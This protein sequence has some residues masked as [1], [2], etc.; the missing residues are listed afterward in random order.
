V[1]NYSQVWTPFYI[2]DS[3]HALIKAK[4]ESKLTRAHSILSLSHTNTTRA[5]R[6][7]TNPSTRPNDV[8]AIEAFKNLELEKEDWYWNLG[9][10]VF[11]MAILVAGDILYDFPSAP[12]TLYGWGTGNLTQYWLVI[13]VQYVIWFGLIAFIL[14]MYTAICITFDWRVWHLWCQYVFGRHRR[15]QHIVLKILGYAMVVFLLAGTM[16]FD[17]LLFYAADAFSAAYNLA[18]QP[19]TDP[20]SFVKR[21]LWFSLSRNVLRVNYFHLIICTRLCNI[22]TWAGII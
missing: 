13:F 1:R 3:E 21:F 4:T 14:F 18:V 15:V 19:L 12:L 22:I 20:Y 16:A 9:L 11:G 8:E 2:L 6:S 17:V 10:L 7:V 5:G